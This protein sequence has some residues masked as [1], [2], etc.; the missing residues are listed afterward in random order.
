MLHTLQVAN[1]AGML[2]EMP[3]LLST[4]RTMPGA[5]LGH[6][7]VVVAL[8]RA[9]LQLCQQLH[10]PV[11]CVLDDEMTSA[12]NGGQINSYVF[13]TSCVQV[14]ISTDSINIL[15]TSSMLQV[16]GHLVTIFLTTRFNHNL[17]DINAWCKNDTCI[18]CQMNSTSFGFIEPNH[19]RPLALCIVSTASSHNFV[20][21]GTTSPYSPYLHP[22]EL[23]HQAHPQ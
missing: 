14:R 11:L 13:T 3:D 19:W 1:K 2:H 12:N 9:A 21:L 23:L 8:D 18:A 15:V 7:I 6:T 5:P 16:A 22:S 10:H 20:C 17:I 4:L